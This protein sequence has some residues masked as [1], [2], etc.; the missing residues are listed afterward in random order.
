[1]ALQS[2]DSNNMLHTFW[3]GWLNSV[4]FMNTYQ[5]EVESVTL[6]AIERQ[7]DVW[8]QTKEQ[9]EK[10]ELEINKFLTDVNTTLLENMKKVNGE[11]VSNSAEEWSKRGEEVFNNIQ[12]L[13][14][15][16][17]KEDNIKNH[18]EQL[19]SGLKTLIENQ[20]KN[21]EEVYSLL[22]S[23]TDQVKQTFKAIV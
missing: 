6:K 3:D 13:F 7:K 2:Q 1:M 14:G 19:E 9:L 18:L 17:S 4:K 22:E 21:R 10:L 8:I 20:H 16:S 12:K 5:R 11:E 15:A 23:Y